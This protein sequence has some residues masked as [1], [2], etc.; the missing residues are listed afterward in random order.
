M[1]IQ[2][3]SVGIPFRNTINLIGFIGKPPHKINLWE[4]L[5]ILEHKFMFAEC[6]NNEY[7]CENAGDCLIRPVWEK[8][9]ENLRQ[10]FQETT[11]EAIVQGNI[12]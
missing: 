9:Y 5:N 3:L 2:V 7:T 12:A 10:L 4:L 11:L 6:V 8:A 1:V